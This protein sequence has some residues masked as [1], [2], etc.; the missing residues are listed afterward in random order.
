MIALITGGTKGIGK[1][2]AISLSKRGY[3]LILVS[4]NDKGLDEIKSKC[5]TNV[6]FYSYDLSIEEDNYKLLEETKNIDI[7]IYYIF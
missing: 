2:M 7:D 1:E 4:R 3:D 6:T 5:K